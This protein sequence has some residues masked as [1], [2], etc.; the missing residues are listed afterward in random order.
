MNSDTVCVANRKA[1]VEK[2]AKM[3]WYSG[4]FGARLCRFKTDSVM[5][6]SGARAEDVEI[7][8]GTNN[9]SFDISSNLDHIGFRTRGKVLVKSI[10]KDDCKILI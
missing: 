9:Q 4:M 7:V 10:V 6:G 5:K 1:F 8:F 2:D 3:S